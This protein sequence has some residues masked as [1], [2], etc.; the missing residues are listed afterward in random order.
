MRLFFQHQLVGYPEA[1]TDSS[2]YGQILELTYPLIGNYGV[3]KYSMDEGIIKNFESETIKANGLT[4]RSLNEYMD[5]L[6][7]KYWKVAG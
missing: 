4:I 6:T 7:W 5:A 2:Y 1:L 3:P